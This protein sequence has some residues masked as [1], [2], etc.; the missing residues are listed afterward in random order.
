MC[1]HVS[2]SNDHK[3]T[4]TETLKLAGPCWSLINHGGWGVGGVKN[5]S[6][7][8]DENGKLDYFIT[9]LSQES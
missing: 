1:F 2:G 7:K 4:R 6:K 9:L 8:E 5:G 3:N